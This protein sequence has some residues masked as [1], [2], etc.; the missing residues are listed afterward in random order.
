MLTV[1]G[2]GGY[3]KRTEESAYCYPRL[4]PEEADELDRVIEEGCENIDEDGW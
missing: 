3:N 2:R 4:S 1:N